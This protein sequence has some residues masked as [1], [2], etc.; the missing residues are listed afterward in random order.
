MIIVRLLGGLGN[1][2]FQYAIARHLSILKKTT[3]KFDITGFNKDLYK[4]GGTIRN[5]G[6]NIFKIEPIIA[7]DED[8][9]IVKSS[10]PE[11]LERL[12][13]R[14]LNKVISNEVYEQKLFSFDKNIFKSLSNT[15]LIGY[16]QSPKYFNSI[17][18]ILL[19][20]FELREIPTTNEY[21][22][23]DKIKK[24]NSVSIHIRR[25]DYSSN[26]EYFKIHGLCSIEYYQ[27]A[28]ECICKKITNPVFY[29]FSDDMEWVKKNIQIKSTC[30]YV[31][32]ANNEKDY[33]EMH[34]MS[35]CKHNIIANSSFSWWGAWLNQNPEK[36]V[37]A[38]KQWMN[39]PAIDTRDLVP[40]N[41]IRI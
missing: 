31:T 7:T 4:E 11:L 35:L 9:D 34:L 32:E 21:P 3:L 14:F 2:M 33:F 40:A 27:S 12:R 30:I 28:I 1:Q 22:F 41:W 17:R 37:I 19:K 25:G 20:D 8:I 5:F 16:W 18:N 36:V 38:P 26:P 39:D 23:L 29:V 24:D 10:K 15:Y 13:N 6:L